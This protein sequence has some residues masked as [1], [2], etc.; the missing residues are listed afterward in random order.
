MNS[1][2]FAYWLQGFVELNGSEPTKEQWQSIKDHLKTV[3][4][5]VTPD[6]RP[7]LGSPGFFPG[8]LDGKALQ[9]GAIC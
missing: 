1:E 8:V 5:K 6:V 7:S 2:Q 3:F 9:L 4:M